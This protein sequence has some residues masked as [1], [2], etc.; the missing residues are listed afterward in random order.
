MD[1]STPKS[2]NQNNKFGLGTKHE[3]Q[4]SEQ[5]LLAK[6]DELGLLHKF[7]LDLSSITSPQDFTL[8]DR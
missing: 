1:V 3:T 7:E 4:L 2:D 5:K 6:F 8:L